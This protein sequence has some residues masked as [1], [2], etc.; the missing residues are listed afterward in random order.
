MKIIGAA[1]GR[2][3]TKSLQIALEIL[4]FGKCYHMEKLLRN[5]NGVGHWKD[6]ME[7]KKVNWDELFAGY[8]SIVDFPGSM[9]YKELSA[10]Y[11]DSKVILGLRDPETWYKSAYETIFSFDPGILFKMQVGMQA[12]YNKKARNLIQ[13]LQ[14]NDKAIWGKYFEGK[15]KDKAYTIAKYKAHIEAV[16]KEIPK[17]RLLL[18]DVKEGWEPLCEFLNTEVPKEAYPRSNKNEDFATWAKNVVVESLEAK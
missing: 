6:A 17:E 11:P 18:H 8:Q 15:F 3:G 14:L 4:G 12:I 5:P 1:Y 16:K 9:Y 13:V 7:G 10:Y 2:T